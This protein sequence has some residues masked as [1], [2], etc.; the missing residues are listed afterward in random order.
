MRQSDGVKFAILGLI[1]CNTEGLHG[2][3]LRQQCVR[4]VG[5]LWQLTL[6]E[7]YRVLGNLAADGWIEADG[8]DPVAG[9]KTYSI[10]PLGQQGLEAFLLR[11]AVD[12][13]RPRRQELAA[14]LLF[15]RPE[16]LASLV[17][18]ISARRDMYQQQLFLL[19]VQ[20]RK[21]RR[22]PVDPFLVNLLIDGEE[23]SVLAEIEWLNNVCQKL[24]ER[25][26]QTAV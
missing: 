14:K 15:A 22:L 4:V 16:H 11:P 26:G 25:F 20:R 18:L 23:G 19:A 10:T 1:A 8:R 13:P 3:E 17:R 2:Y 24:T 9:R 5:H 21:L 12:L 6:Q 7:V